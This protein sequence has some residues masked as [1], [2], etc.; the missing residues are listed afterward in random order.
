MRDNR[1]SESLSAEAQHGEAHPGPHGPLWRAP[2]VILLAGALT[3]AA[4]L[5]LNLV[6]LA[7]VAWLASKPAGLIE[8]DL[9][10][11]RFT[12]VQAALSATLSV[13]LALPWRGH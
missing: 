12:L 6:P 10:A 1:N 3:A 8:A 11:L 7:A 4:V 9:A 2:P 5:L 13:A